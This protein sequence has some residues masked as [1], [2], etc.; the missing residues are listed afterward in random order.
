MMVDIGMFLQFGVCGVRVVRS[1]DVVSAVYSA[2]S[3][4]SK[5]VLGDW[6]LLFLHRVFLLIRT[7]IINVATNT[8]PNPSMNIDKVRLTPC[9]D[10]DAPGKVEVVDIIGPPVVTEVVPKVVV[11]CLC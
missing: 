3:Q 8:H 1:L 9:D 11:V 6:E 2:V 7:T 10:V 5:S 4:E